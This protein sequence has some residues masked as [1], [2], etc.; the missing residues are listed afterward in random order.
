MTDADSTGP[1]HRAWA[2]SWLS[3]ASYYTGRKGFSVVKHTLET[4]FGVHAAALGVIDTVYSAAYAV[5]QLG[6]GWLGDTLGAR[7]LIG[8]GMLLSAACCA[9]FGSSSTALAFGVV[10]CINGFAQSTGWPGTTRTMAEWTTRENRGAVMGWWAT[11]YQ[12]GGLA[13]GLGAG[14]LLKHAGWRSTFYVPAAWMAVVAGAVLLWLPLGSA[15]ATQGRAAPASAIGDTDASARRTAQ[16]AVFGSGL[17]WC[18][19]TSYFFIKFIRYALLFWLPYYLTAR[20][21]YS[22]DVSA[23]L[24]QAFEIG[25]VPG[26]ILIGALSSRLPRVS[27]SAIAALWLVGLAGA[28]FAY[29][30]LSAWGMWGNAL[31]IGLVGMMLFGPDSLISGAAAQDA[32]GP[33]AAATATGFVNGVGSFGA[34]LEGLAVPWISKHWGWQAVFPVFLAMALIGAAALVPTIARAP[35]TAPVPTV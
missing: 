28:V 31:G 9:A 34:I 2:L 1:R 4:T 7:R 15:G 12:V 27:R 6:S 25:G 22:G 23:Y 5:G 17:L 3:Y 13:A 21:A 35:R 18:Y 29:I 26:V 32:G 19:G 14:W 11:C 10:F 33:L 8:W 16:R 20:F 30:R 24:S